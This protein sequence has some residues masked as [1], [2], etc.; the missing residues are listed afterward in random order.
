MPCDDND[1]EGPPA[2]SVIAE[3]R[4]VTDVDMTPFF[5]TDLTFERKLA[6]LGPRSTHADSIK[7]AC[8]D[9]VAAIDWARTNVLTVHLEALA[10]YVSLT[11]RHL[12]HLDLS[13]NM[14]GPSGA[15]VLGKAL[16]TN[17]TLETLVLQRTQL[18][19]S[20]YRPSFSGLA[21]LVKGLESKRS[22]LRR[23]NLA[24]SGLQPN[25]VRLICCALAFHRTLT[26]LDISNN[27]AGLFKD[28]Q[29]YT[30]LASLIRFSK[31]LRMLNMSNNP[32]ESG[33]GPV[34]LEALVEN[35]AL[36][37]LHAAGCKLTEVLGASS[38]LKFDECTL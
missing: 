3:T 26:A 16:L 21:V 28:K 6:V 5:E 34:L 24:E 38:L 29:G 35:P 37:V 30:A 4:S 11:S 25:G 23:V 32:F 14:L 1:N 33:A 31:T 10:V 36:T 7:V 12:V 20:P 2:P 15:E 9:D 18:T 17:N 22:V 13:F 8:R 19:G 27:Q